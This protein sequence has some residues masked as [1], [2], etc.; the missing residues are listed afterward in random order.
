[1]ICRVLLAVLSA[2]GHEEPVDFPVI[3]QAILPVYFMVGVGLALRGLKVLTPEMERGM[4]KMIIHCLY[5]CLILDKT[6]G[7]SLVRQPDVLMWGVGLGFALVIAGMGLSYGLAR[8]MGLQAGNGRRTFCVAAGTQNFGYIAV[9]LLTALFVVGGNDQVLGVLFVHSLGVEIALWVFGVMIMTG[10]VFGNPKAMINGPTVAVVLGIVFSSTGLWRFFDESGGGVA[11][12]SLRQGMSWLGAC[13]FPMG[14]VVIGA[15]MYDLIG[16][17]RISVKI[18]SGS[19][20]VRIVVMPMFFLAAAYFL[21]L[22]TELRQV[23]VVQAS[24]PAAVSPIILARHY[25]GSAGVAVQAVIVTSV[26]A[27]ITMPL[28]IS[29]GI[30]IVFG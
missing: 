6:L 11:G 22:I 5:P 25:G 3:L 18:A 29:R 15:T 21:P 7:N 9:P 13:A 2:A 20:L 8:L 19:L 12:A 17:E 24:M 28:W 16:K 27:L 1:L 10:S 30:L 23:L 4:L 26:V 14:L